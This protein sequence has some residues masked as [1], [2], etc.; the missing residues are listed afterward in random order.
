MTRPRDSIYALAK[1]MRASMKL[2]LRMAD[3]GLIIR[4]FKNDP[5]NL[6]AIALHIKYICKDQYLEK[7]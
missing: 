1:E 3:C 2:H 5:H 4:G 6:T 7:R